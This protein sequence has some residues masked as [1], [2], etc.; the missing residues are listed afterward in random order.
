M[1]SAPTY[2]VFV[3]LAGGENLLGAVH[4]ALVPRLGEVDEIGA[5]ARRTLAAR[6]LLFCGFD[7]V[8]LVELA[9]PRDAVEQAQ[10]PSTLLCAR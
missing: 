2:C 6:F 8:P 7:V 3:L 10:P 4:G 1:L 5:G 9:V